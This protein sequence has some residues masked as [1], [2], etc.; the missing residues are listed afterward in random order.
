LTAPIKHGIAQMTGYAYVG[1]TL[2][3]QASM[4]ARI[5]KNP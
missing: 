3:C 4:T 2:V 1:N 5:V